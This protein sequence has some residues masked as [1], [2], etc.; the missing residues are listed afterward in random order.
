MEGCVFV[1]K[2][3]ELLGKQD[4]CGDW[5]SSFHAGPLSSCA[6]GCAVYVSVPGL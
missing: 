6:V 4:G 1:M 5:Y 2:G 3:G